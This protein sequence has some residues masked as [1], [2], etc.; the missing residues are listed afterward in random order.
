MLTILYDDIKQC[1]S[2]YN[3]MM[4]VKEVTMFRNS[5]GK[6]NVSAGHWGSG[7]EVHLCFGTVPNNCLPRSMDLYPDLHSMWP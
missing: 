4:Y 3:V 7:K 2:C 1:V 5:E 6:G